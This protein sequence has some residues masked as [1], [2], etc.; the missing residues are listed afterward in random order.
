MESKDYYNRRLYP[1]LSPLGAWALS[2]GTAIG[3]GS[4]VVTGN[5]Y[6]LKAGPLGSVIAILLGMVAMLVIARSYHYLINIFPDAGGAYTFSKEVFGYDWGFMTSWFLILTYLAMLW[7]NLTSLPLFAR[8]FLGN[9][10][11]FGYLYTFLGYDIY[12][13]EAVLCLIAMVLTILFCSRNKKAVEKAMI[14]MAAVFT[15][16]ILLVFVLAM[17]KA[18]GSSFSAQLFMLPEQSGFSQIFRVAIMSPWAFVGFENISHSAEGFDF[19]YK[20]SFRIMAAAI[21]ISTAL[22]IFVILLSVSAY[23]SRFGSWF[24][25]LNN[26]GSLSG[27]EGLP[28]FY[29]AQ[30]YLGDL[31]V[32][33]L[34]I[35]LLCLIITSLIGNMVALSRLFMAM[36]KDGI[37]NEKY[38]ELNSLFIPDRAIRLIGIMTLLIPFIGRTAIGAV[39]D[40]TTIGATL[41]YGIVSVSAFRIARERKDATETGTGLIGVTLMGIFGAYLLFANIFNP[42]T[43]SV[44]AYILF[45]IWAALGFVYFRNVLKNDKEKKFGHSIIVWIALLSLILFTSMIWANQRVLGATSTVLEEAREHFA[46]SGSSISAEDLNFIAQ[47]NNE[48]RQANIEGFLLVIGV[49]VLSFIILM[50]N[51]NMMSDRVQQSE[52]ALGLAN[53]RANRDPLTGV[54]SKY[55]YVEAENMINQKIENGEMEDFAVAVFDVN[56]LKHI[57]DTHGHQFGDEYIRLSCGIICQQF[58]RSPVYRVGGDEFA[59]LLT[60]EDYENRQE[61]GEEISKLSLQNNSS[62]DYRLPVIAMGIEEYKRGEDA[63]I[64]SV[65]ERADKKMYRNKKEL[66]NTS[67]FKKE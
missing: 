45:T 20:R 7:A 56:D 14:G 24:E 30:Y 25:Y 27:L 32:D 28:A 61:L 43:M 63:N 54:K 36:A 44:E 19:S 10:F 17:L 52:A 33:I 31:G 59:A 47:K 53:D 13:G 12:F 29:A 46:G 50:N 34:I 18:R 55:A 26:L 6:L 38:A 23:P 21:L 37:L 60:G 2:I 49:F 41:V 1:Y 57:N 58:K 8:Y 3:W 16:G 5:D 51:Y 15:A 65:F 42:G 22:Y 39:V 48:V 62:D 64:H 11:R 4:F 40:V 35:S 67:V 9:F 66:K